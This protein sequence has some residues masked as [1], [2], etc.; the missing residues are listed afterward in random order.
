MVSTL[1]FRA[2][3]SKPRAGMEGLMGEIGEVR[4]G[5]DPQGLIFV[6]GEL[7]SAVSDEKIEPGE[8]VEVLGAEG[9]LLKVKRAT[10]KE[11]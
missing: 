6:H 1:A 4:E 7:W 5:I 3:R 9:L 10:G 8:K 2:Y 11:S